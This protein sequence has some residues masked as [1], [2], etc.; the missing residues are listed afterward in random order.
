MD[1]KKRKSRFF[2]EMTD[3]DKNETQSRSWN[4]DEKKPKKSSPT[5]F[6]TLLQLPMCYCHSKLKQRI[7]YLIFAFTNGLTYPEKVKLL[8]T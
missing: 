5:S 6:P 3:S 1:V 4:P 8:V 7:K 2:L